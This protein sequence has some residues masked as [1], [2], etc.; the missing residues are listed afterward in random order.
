MCGVPALT[1]GR[2]WWVCVCVQVD[3]LVETRERTLLTLL[4]DTLMTHAQAFYWMRRMCQ[5]IRQ[6]VPNI[7]VLLPAALPEIDGGE[8]DLDSPLTDLV[9]FTSPG[10]SSATT[11]AAQA[12]PD[13]RDS[14][15]LYCTLD[16]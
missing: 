12:S 9:P 11:P 4:Y 14:P 1:K 10:L 8:S 13:N 15:L 2:M 16:Q 6:R 5:Y 7:S 3:I